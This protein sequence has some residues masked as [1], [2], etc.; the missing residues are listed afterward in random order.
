MYTVQFKLLRYLI[1]Y[2]SPFPITTRDGSERRH[3]VP[4]I[5][6]NYEFFTDVALICL[7]NVTE[8]GKHWMYGDTVLTG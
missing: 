5:H 6:V 4:G 2:Y 7:R 1:Q 3:S 8:F